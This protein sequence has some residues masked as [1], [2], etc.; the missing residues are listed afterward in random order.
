M[1]TR[2]RPDTARGDRSRRS[3]GA[4]SSRCASCSS[5]RPR[6]QGIC[7]ATRSPPGWTSTRSKRPGLEPIAPLLREIEGAQDQW[8]VLALLPTLHRAGIFA[9]FGWGVT[10][11]H[12]DSD[13]YLL[14]LVQAGLGLADR[15]R[16][17]DPSDAAVELRAAYVEHV[18]AQL[19]HVGFG[20]ERAGSVLEFETQLAG[21]HLKGEERRDVERTHN[22]YTRG[23]LAML[24]PELSL[25]SHLQRARRGRRRERERRE[26][27]AVR[28]AGRGRGD[29]RARHAARVPRVHRRADARQRAAQ[30]HRRR[31]LRVLRPADQ[32]PDRAAR[33]HQARHRRDRR[34]PGGGARG[35]LRRGQLRAGGQGARGH[36]GG[37]DRRG[38][39][40]LDPHARVDGRRDP[41]ARRGQARRDPGQDRL[42]RP[43]AR[44]VRARARP[45][46]VRGQPAR[47]RR[48]SSSTASSRS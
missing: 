36:D 34:G 17:F 20:A 48:A 21:L 35:A 29:D 13:R 15:E 27:A 30:A 39:A 46:D 4:T 37:G 6:R 19:A 40:R 47:R 45:H 25:A 1:P 10:V 33:T 16:Y 42:P 14:W 41:R 32:G 26:H 7:S 44:L 31:G 8:A 11:D 38:D 28:G 3:A 43:L 2:S 18:G 9:L 5:A 12:D 23:E 24:A 22:R